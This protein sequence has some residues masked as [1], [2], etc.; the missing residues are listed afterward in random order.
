MTM[1]GLI[2]LE[3]R[4]FSLLLWDWEKAQSSEDFIYSWIICQ[5]F[6]FFKIKASS[7]CF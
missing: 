5:Y 6:G 4:D 3:Q 1:N 7:G 2:N